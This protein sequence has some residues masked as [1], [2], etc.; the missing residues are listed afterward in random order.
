MRL[1]QGWRG[2]RRGGGW[3]AR[4]GSEAARSGWGFSISCFGRRFAAPGFRDMPPAFLFDLTNVD[5][6][7]VQFGPDVIRQYNQQ[8]FEFEMLEGV[9]HV[10]TAE[11]ELAGFKDVRADEFWCRG[12]VPGR[13]IFPG[14]LQI[15]LAAQLAGF[16]TGQV[17][18]WKGF[19]GFAGVDE[20][21]FRGMVVP[22]DRLHVL[23]KLVSVRHGRVKCATQ[24]LVKGQLMF[25][26]TITGMLL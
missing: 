11:A 15:E 9:S 2:P 20:V 18:Q 12:H 17:L 26:A 16:Y 14:V 22:G 4:R 25:E 1:S 21:K 23:A 3:G 8:R 13:P 10:N 24:G 6:D 19:L 7:R 5:L